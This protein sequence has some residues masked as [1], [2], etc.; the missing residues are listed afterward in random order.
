MAENVDLNAGFACWCRCEISPSW[1][2]QLTLKNVH[3]SV[4][5]NSTIKNCSA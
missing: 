2:W 4:T 5:I 1:A 3:L